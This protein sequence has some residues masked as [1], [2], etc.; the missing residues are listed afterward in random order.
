MLDY[1]ITII[2]VLSGIF[3]IVDFIGN[4]LKKGSISSSDL[5]AGFA[6]IISAATLYCGLTGTFSKVSNDGS[7]NIATSAGSVINGTGGTDDQSPDS[8][9]VD[10]EQIYQELEAKA[11]QVWIEN[12]QILDYNNDYFNAEYRFDDEIVINTG[13]TLK[14][15][16]IFYSKGYLD[17]VSHNIDF[18]LN[19]QYST[20]S[21]TLALSDET[22][23]TLCDWR[24]DIVVDN[25]EVGSFDLKSGSLPQN[26]N[27]DT[28]NATLLRI[29]VH[30]KKEDSRYYD[31]AEIVFGDASFTKS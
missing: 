11:T 15:S 19:K 30:G 5:I 22:K 23:N 6:I 13:D 21:A 10:P 17:D 26:I 18:Y 29:K 25:D 24:I 3:G 12:V 7:S 31:V 1:I 14:H 16:L 9:S 8:E 28:S 27:I 2:G 20:F 4:R